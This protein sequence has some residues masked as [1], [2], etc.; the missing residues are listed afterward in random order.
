[1]LSL[2]TSPLVKMYVAS[3]LPEEYQVWLSS[4]VINHPTR[5]PEFLLSDE[6]QLAF[7]NLIVAYR[8]ST[9]P[10]VGINVTPTLSTPTQTA[11]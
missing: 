7:Q 11:D 4:E 6:G 2:L 5:F 1:M 9:K 3:V 8:K 10:K